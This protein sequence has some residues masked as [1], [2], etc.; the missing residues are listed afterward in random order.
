[1]KKILGLV[2][3]LMLLNILVSPHFSA[4]ENLMS[5][6]VKISNNLEERGKQLRAAIDQTYKK[7]SEAHAIKAMPHSDENDLTSVVVQYIP[8][9][10]SFDD[11]EKILRSAGFK[12][13][14]RPSTNSPGIPGDNTPKI[15]DERITKS[16]IATIDPYSSFLDGKITIGVF[17]T[18]ESPTDFTKVSK[19]HAGIGAS[20]L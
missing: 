9:G 10:T 16:V 17:L 18:P 15:Q 11:A 14:P 1:M 19:I 3:I 4:A 8:L 7:M 5:D 12:V 6:N 13:G 20:Y 2:F